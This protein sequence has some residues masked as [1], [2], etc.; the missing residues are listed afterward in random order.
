MKRVVPVIAVVLA[1]LSTPFV[2]A[3][4]SLS[5]AQLDAIRTNC[6][7]AQISLQHVQESDKLTRINRGYRYESMLKLMTSFNSRVAENKVDAPDLISIASEYQ[8]TWDSFRTEYSNYDDSMTALTQIDCKSEPTTFSDQLAVL[9]IKRTGLN[10]RVKEFD[11][12]LDK[13]QAGVDDVRKAQEK[14]K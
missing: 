2:R 6:V 5:D 12:L 9:R 14:S 3:E 10:N 8:R 13:Y 11:S 7:N 4:G 1:L